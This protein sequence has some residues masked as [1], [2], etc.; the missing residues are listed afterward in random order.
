MRVDEVEITSLS[1]QDN[2]GQILGYRIFNDIFDRTSFKRF[3]VKNTTQL[4]RPLS[5]LDTEIYV[6]NANVLT[7]PSKPRKAPG[8]VLIDGERI[9]FYHINNNVLSQLRRG[10]LG[11]GSKYYY[12]IGSKVI[13]Q[14]SLQ[15]I[16]FSE[17]IRKQVLYTSENQKSY[18][19]HTTAYTTQTTNFANT[20]TSDGITLAQIPGVKSVDQVTVYYGSRQL[21][22][23][24][25]LYHDVT[26]AYDSQP[27]TLVGSLSSELNLPLTSSIGDA[28]RIT[29]NNK[30]WV[31]S[32]STEVDAIHGFVYRGLH[33]IES[34]FT[35]NTS[36]QVISLNIAE[37]I[38]D[39][40]K[41]TIVKKDFARNTVWNDEITSVQTASLLDST[42]K[43]AKFLK[44]KPAELPNIYYYGG[45][46]VLQADG[47]DLLT[48][49][50]RNPLE[51]I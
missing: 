31:Q 12:D 1:N 44:E 38:I 35:I 40:V 51:G 24:P 42:T 6:V 19:I 50:D 34:E 2:L 37:P 36:T 23:V 33:Y 8:V 15:T 49:D 26:V 46:P 17:T 9:E 25:T 29:S 3:S 5:Y 10:T 45:Q 48:D 22:K 14:G 13:D 21:N 11:T 39:N 7:P 20:V 32:G 30:V 28:Y 16:P 27:Y 43:Q 4:A 47:G 18:K 41:L